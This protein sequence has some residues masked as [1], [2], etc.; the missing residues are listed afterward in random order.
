MAG[1]GQSM[2]AQCR[3]FEA[4]RGAPVGLVRFRAMEW[5]ESLE[6]LSPTQAAVLLYLAHRIDAQHNCRPGR[7]RIARATKLHPNSVTRAIH[8]L[9]R[10][11]WITVSRRRSRRGHVVYAGIRLNAPAPVRAGQRNN[12]HAGAATLDTRLVFLESTDL[13]LG[14]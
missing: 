1:A 14:S 13:V 12:G 3:H 5:V 2:N 7:Q 10:Q 6:E 8:A 9:E 11:N 4:P